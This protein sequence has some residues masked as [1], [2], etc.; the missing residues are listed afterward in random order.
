MDGGKGGVAFP[1]SDDEEISTD[2]QSWLHFFVILVS[3]VK[4]VS[5]MRQSLPHLLTIDVAVI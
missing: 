4:S 5:L 2:G 1:Q 3:P